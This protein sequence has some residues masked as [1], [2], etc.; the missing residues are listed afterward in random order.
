MLADALGLNAAER[1]ELA[2]TAFPEMSGLVSDEAAPDSIPAAPPENDVHPTQAPLEITPPPIPPTRLIGR[3][4]ELDRSLELLR[5]EDIRLVTLT[6][7]G[8]VGKTRLALAAAER[9]AGERRFADGVAF[10]DLSPISDPKMVPSAVSRA[11][12]LPE[13]GERLP[14]DR[15]RSALQRRSLLLALDNFEHLLPAVPVVSDLLAGCPGLVVLATSRERLHLRGEREAQIEPMRLPP[16]YAGGSVSE[17]DDVESLVSSFD[18]I[19]L[20]VERAQEAQPEFTLNEANAATIVEIA[21]RLDGLP[22][23]IELAAARIRVLPPTALLNRLEQRLSILTGGARDLPAHQQ[24]LRN[25]IAWSFDLLTPAEQSMFR[26][27]SVF[28]GGFTMP[29]AEAVTAEDGAADQSFD[30]ISSLVDKHLLR[31]TTGSD[32]EPRYLMLETIREFGLELLAESGD[33]ENTR[34]RHAHW[35][36]NFAR[37]GHDVLTKFSDHDEWQQRLEADL[38]NLR[39]AMTWANQFGDIE[40]GLN[41]SGSLTMFWY[42]SGR[43]REGR[44]WINTFLGQAEEPSTARAWALTGAGLTSVYLGDRD[45]ADDLLAASHRMFLM[46]GD[47]GSA[48]YPKLLHGINAED[49]GDFEFAAARLEEARKLAVQADNV[50]VEANI[51][52]HEGI[53]AWGQGDITR[54]AG[55]LEEAID[56]ATRTESIYI[57]AWAMSRLGSLYMVQGQFA[58]AARLLA[59][60]SVR[61]QA[62]ANAYLIAGSIATLAAFAAGVDLPERA[63]RLFAADA[64]QQALLG[65]THAFPERAVYDEGLALARDVLDADTFAS[66]WEAG[67]H[68]T[69]EQTIAEARALIDIVRQRPDV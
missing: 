40:T 47:L 59:E 4:A 38:D 8:G 14:V 50:P 32:G 53:V 43:F 19:A 63:A 44:S 49:Q 3:K 39:L 48:A 36:A 9:L 56:L 6:G 23:A 52:Y 7:P 18:A 60:A 67:R 17:S 42:F 64:A 68:L 27:L 25:T 62:F 16:S 61:E 54:A 29:A 41:V 66:A 1:A 58:D 51:R 26:R 33:G 2:A 57:A 69:L 13:A 11:L 15:L 28:T 31:Q 10:V 20:F 45:A 46:L 30:L 22:L 5:R 35:F 21:R 55:Y 12:G 65:F 34:R 24:T 37:Q